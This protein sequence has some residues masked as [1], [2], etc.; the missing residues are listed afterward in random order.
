MQR[1]ANSPLPHCGHHT[2]KNEAKGPAATRGEFAPPSL[3]RGPADG[4]RGRLPG[5]EGRIRPSL[6]AAADPIA[7]RYSIRTNEGRIRPSLIA[8]AASPPA[9]Y[10]RLRQRGANSP[11]PHCGGW[12]ARQRSRSAAS[13]RGEFAPPS[14]R[15]EGGDASPY[16]D[17]PTR[18]E[19]AP[20]SLRQSSAAVMARRNAPNEGRI[21][22]SL[23]A[24]VL[25]VRYCLRCCGNEGRIRPSLIAALKPVGTT[26]RT[27]TTR[28]EFAPPSLRHLNRVAGHHHLVTTR[29]EFAPPS[30]RPTSTAP[31]PPR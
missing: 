2:G 14:L 6:I 1:G 4:G 25:R 19:F 15:R 7:F 12:E 31:T 23:I 11:L 13:T 27:I 3:R 26:T 5:N 9:G 24:A 17:G 8:A 28:G 22:P 29:G 18:G 30:L 20:P 21:R 10:R 16:L